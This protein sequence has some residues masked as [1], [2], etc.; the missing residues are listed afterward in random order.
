MNELISIIV[1][2]YKVENEIGRCV[3]CLRNQTYSNI[4]IILVDDGSPDRCPDLCDKYAKSDNRIRVIHKKNGGLSDARNAGL[5]DANGEYVLF[6]DSDDYIEEDACEKLVTFMKEGVDFVVGVCRQINGRKI[7]YQKHT[8]LEVGRAYK[9]RDYIIKS[10]TNME[11]YAP[12]WLNLYRRSFLIENALFYRVGYYYEDL[13]IQPRMCLLAN[14]IVYSDVVFYNYVIR[15]NSIMTSRITDKKKRMII[16]I[17]NDWYDTVSRLKDRE[18]KK[19][20]SGALAK[21]YVASA[22]SMGI[23]GWKVNGVTFKF[24]M[25]NALNEK[26][27]IK[28]IIYN[29]APTVY[30]FL[31]RVKSYICS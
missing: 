2:V 13:D 14:K 23:R 31:I 7:K 11:W 16:D 6:V 17:Y 3:R 28:Y 8:N 12:A 15:E 4:E 25:R 26:E 9:S 29:F 21:H 10:I 30:S 5:K 22:S 20:I 18:L 27:K 1:P 19:Y 24:A